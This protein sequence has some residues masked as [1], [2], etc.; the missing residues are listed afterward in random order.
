[1]LWIRAAAAPEAR[2][3][4]VTRRW[5]CQPASSTM[6]HSRWGWDSSCVGTG[7]QVFGV[8]V[9]VVFLRDNELSRDTRSLRAAMG[10][11]QATPSKTAAADVGDVADAVRKVTLADP[12]KADPE[13][14]AGSNPTATAASASASAVR[15]EA[16]PDPS[17]REPTRAGN[18]KTYLFR[19]ER[20]KR[21]E[22]K[23][24]RDGETAAGDLPGVTDD[25]PMVAGGPG[26]KY[27]RPP[28]LPPR[29]RPPQRFLR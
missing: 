16:A 20:S 21:G 3:E 26:E 22:T 12:P 25:V 23:K 15:R 6:T 7:D 27:P 14:D 29:R 19:N 24:K 8:P 13:S 4:M 2:A 10:N 17:E 5:R 9:F 28:R 11:K 1:M 18:K